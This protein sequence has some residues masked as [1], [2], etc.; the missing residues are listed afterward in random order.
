MSSNYLKRNVY[1]PSWQGS[2][3]SLA[4]K[5]AREP[6]SVTL[7]MQYEET[8][9]DIEIAMQSG[10]DSEEMHDLM[11]QLN[12]LSRQIKDQQGL[13]AHLERGRFC[14]AAREHLRKEYVSKY[15]ML[16]GGG[17]TYPYPPGSDPSLPAETQSTPLLGTK[18]G[19]LS[20]M[21]DQSVRHGFVQKVY[22]ILFVQLL[23]TAVIASIVM[24]R[25][26]G[27]PSGLVTAC[28]FISMA[29]MIGV[30]CLCMCKPGL[31][32]SYP[33]NYVILFV[34]TL[35]ESVLVGFIGAR[36][37]QES[38]LIVACVT[39]AVVLGLS[40]FACQTS[41]DFSGWGPYLMC[42]LLVMIGFSFCFVIGAMAGQANSEAFQTLRLIFACFGALLFS[43]YIIY[44]TQLIMGGKHETQFAIDDYCLAAL[45]LYLD[46]VQL[47]LYMLEIFGGRK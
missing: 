46:I 13:A 12:A 34:F 25:L 6:L 5:R 11:A 2:S 1:P 32:R 39:A 23:F 40:I 27:A 45:S 4:A 16:R 9:R 30:S 3:S 47:F 21:T 42:A 31:M 43:F 24:S 20:E 10:A 26:E 15:I 29:V 41:Y 44:D 7:A 37:T 38:V 36:Y 22:G 35:A 28:F 14:G 17:P 8:L 19:F 33:T 18:D